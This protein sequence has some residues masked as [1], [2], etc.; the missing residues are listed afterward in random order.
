MDSRQL[1]P[2]P[3]PNTTRLAPISSTPP[4][5]AGYAIRASLA[6]LPCRTCHLK[7]DA[8]QPSCSQCRLKDIE[9]AYVKSRRG[10]TDNS[11]RTLQRRADQIQQRRLEEREP[12]TTNRQLTPAMP[13]IGYPAPSSQSSNPF[14]PGSTLSSAAESSSQVGEINATPERLVDTY[15]GITDLSL[16]RGL[17]INATSEKLVDLYYKFFHGAHPFILPKDGLTDQWRFD[18]STMQ[19]LILAIQFVGSI[20][21]ESTAPDIRSKAFGAAFESNSRPNGY[22][23]QTYLQSPCTYTRDFRVKHEKPR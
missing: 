12:P 6:C 20:Y 16:A 19:P 18:N 10:P 21:A 5:N 1:L 13:Y 2:R 17:E 15:I 11:R 7:C 4:A 22:L 3:E 8:Y 9:C 23:V 14:F